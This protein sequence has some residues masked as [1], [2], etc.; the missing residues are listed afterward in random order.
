ME[1]KF[2]SVDEV[3]KFTDAIRRHIVVESDIRPGNIDPEAFVQ[4]LNS[5]A[6]G[7]KIAAI[8]LYR[9]VFNAG[10]RESKDAVERAP[11]FAP[12]FWDR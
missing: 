4:H 9:A 1:L 11:V 2:N 7:D 6:K 8:K 5:V 3:L 12:S 10:L